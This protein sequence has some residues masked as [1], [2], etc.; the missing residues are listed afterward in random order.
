MKTLHTLADCVNYAKST[1]EYKRLLDSH[2]QLLA[3]LEKLS[4]GL[5][6]SG[7]KHYGVDEAIAKAKGQL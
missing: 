5:S 2:T 4:N 1:P 7:R 6:V 3:M